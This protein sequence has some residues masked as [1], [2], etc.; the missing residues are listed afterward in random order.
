MVSRPKRKFTTLRK[1]D[2][3]LEAFYSELGE[4]E[5]YFLGNWIIDED[6][7]DDENEAAVTKVKQEIEEIKEEHVNIE[8]T[9]KE[10]NKKW[11]QK[12]CKN[13]TET[14][15]QKYWSYSKW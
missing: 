11:I 5:E 2:A 8:N 14:K 15:I 4:G 12:F 3:L 10:K 9:V 1:Q 13:S 6:D 7:I